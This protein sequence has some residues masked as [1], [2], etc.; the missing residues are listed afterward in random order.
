MRTYT[1]KIDLLQQLQT[2]IHD[3]NKLFEALSEMRDEYNLLDKEC[4][5]LAKV[6]LYLTISLP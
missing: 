1:S 3:G 5:Q 6:Y 4:L 2:L